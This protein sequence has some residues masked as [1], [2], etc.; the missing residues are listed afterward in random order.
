MENI[1]IKG[2][3][4][5][6][7]RTRQTPGK[8]IFGT[9]RNGEGRHGTKISRMLKRGSLA[10]RREDL[11]LDIMRQEIGDEAVQGQGDAVANI[12]VGACDQRNP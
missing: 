10:H 3:K 7:L 12:V 5:V 9:K 1:G 2:D 8:A 6:P 11:H 4:L